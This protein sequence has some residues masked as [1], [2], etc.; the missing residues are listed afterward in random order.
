IRLVR[1]MGVKIV[2]QYHDEILIECDKSRVEWVQRKLDVCIRRVNEI[3]SL[4]VVIK[5]DY[6][7]GKTYGDV[8]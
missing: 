3:L 6:K 2:M 7:T 5:I 1:S 8:H 4:N